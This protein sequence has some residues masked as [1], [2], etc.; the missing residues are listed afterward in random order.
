MQ[1]YELTVILD[2]GILE[3][4]VPQALDKLN[5]LITKYGGEVVETD[6]WGR[7]RLSY[8]IKRHAEGNYVMTRME[9]EPDSTSELESEM[10]IT[11]D[12]L[13]H[14]LIKVGE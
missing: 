1:Q 6:H 10:N 3:E 9:M 13:R 14:L 12:Y 5:S 8:P 4:D 2:P 7:R 11:L